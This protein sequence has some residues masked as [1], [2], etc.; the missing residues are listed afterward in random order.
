VK[1]FGPAYEAL[2]MTFR[3]QQTRSPS[4]GTDR[5]WAWHHLLLAVGNFKAQMPL[6]PPRLPPAAGR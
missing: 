4:R 6:F 1:E 3:R 2:R 5:S